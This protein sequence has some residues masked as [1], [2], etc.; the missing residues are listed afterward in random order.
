MEGVLDE[1][2]RRVIECG[3]M[4][5]EVFQ[6]LQCGMYGECVKSVHRVCE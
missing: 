1:Y 2:T 4:W 5:T 6:Y 3:I